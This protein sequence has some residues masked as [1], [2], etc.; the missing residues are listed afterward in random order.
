MEHPK[1]LN[2]LTKRFVNIGSQ[3]FNKL[4][5]QGILKP[6]EDIEVIT[7]MTTPIVESSI[8]PVI[9]PVVEP[10]IKKLLAQ[11]MA[12]LV[13]Q[14]KVLFQKE[15]SQKESD[16]LFRKLLY[17][18]LS[19]MKEPKPTKPEKKK[20]KPKKKKKAKYKMVTPAPS[21]SSDTDSD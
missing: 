9:E 12:E 13:K 1:I 14:N 4:V 17:E 6:V 5:L 21:S 15:L 7:P 3:Q 8:D 16:A 20:E 10:P 18:K 11:N 19:G 2:P